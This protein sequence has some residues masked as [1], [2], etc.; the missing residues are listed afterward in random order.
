MYSPNRDK[1]LWN[2]ALE[3]C[4]RR[5]DKTCKHL[6]D[7]SACE[8]CPF[9]IKNYGNF[10]PSDAMLF[11]MQA[12]SEA[13]DMKTQGSVYSKIIIG[14]VLFFV[15][16]AFFPTCMNR[17]DELTGK[18]PPNDTPPSRTAEHANIEIAQHAVTRY[19]RAGHD[20]NNDGLTNCIDA[21]VIFYQYYPNKNRV[22]I[23]VNRNSDGS[24][25]HLFNS[26]LTDGSWKYIEPQAYY[27]KYTSYW[28]TSVWKSEYNYRY[29]RDA[30]SEYR[31]YVR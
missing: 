1:A 22:R 10:S 11:M 21:A 28:M 18:R 6:F 15:W 12:Q 27:K 9:F 17:M 8:K 26:V 3:C 4:L 13:K 5:I 23:I 7:S 30:T 29:N 20:V 19:M 16:L 14:I 24:M 2:C 25:H 31:R